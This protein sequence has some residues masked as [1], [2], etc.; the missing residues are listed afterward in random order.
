[1]GRTAQ[2]I[3]SVRMISTTPSL[4]AK[5][6]Y[7]ILGLKKDASAKDIKKAYYKLAKNYHPDVNKEKD[8][9]EKFQEVGEAYEVLSDEGKRRQYDQFGADPFGGRSTAG[10]HSGAGAGAGAGTWN[11]QGG[12]DFDP[13]KIF[14]DF[15]MKMRQGGSF[16]DNMHG[17][18]STQQT[19]VNITFEEAARGGNKTIPINV[20]DDCEKC[21]GGGCEP[22]YK[23]L[24]DIS[25]PRIC[26]RRQIAL[27][28]LSARQ[29]ATLSPD[30]GW[31]CLKT[32]CFLPV[33]QR[34]RNDDAT[35][36]RVLH[37]KLVRPLPRLGRLQ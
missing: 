4:D 5:D 20:V 30:V 31:T 17:F 3:N 25:R 14:R 16:A 34:H 23:K 32:R 29:P 22:G 2:V 11:F 9:A 1:M 19:S 13:F 7:K 6:Y 21:K 37:A 15:D 36:P 28:D 10:A 27:P 8:A 35:H 33:L 12:G 18:G 26:V 24:N